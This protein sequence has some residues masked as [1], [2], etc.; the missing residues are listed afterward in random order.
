[1]E[2][3]KNMNLSKFQKFTLILSGVIALTVGISILADPFY[4]YKSYAIFLPDNPN[5]LSELRGPAANLAAMGTIMLAGAFYRPMTRTSITTAKTVFIAFPI[6]RLVSI[7][8]DGIPS[9]GILAALYV[10]LLIAA[11]LVLAFTRHSM[12]SERQ[13]DTFSGVSS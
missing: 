2:W 1:M 3:R 12:P 7:T 13:Q 6:G 10:E 5:L 11:F 9:E 4:F 8:V